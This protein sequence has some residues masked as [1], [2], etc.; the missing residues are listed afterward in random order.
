[1]PKIKIFVMTHTSFTPPKETMYEPLHVGRALGQE[2][3]YTGDDSGDN[4]SELNPLFGELT[5]F[6]WLWKNLPY[7][8]WEDEEDEY[9]ELD[10]L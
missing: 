10:D 5:G 7:I 3:G 9:F 8:S 6:Y 1:M 4:I 2:L